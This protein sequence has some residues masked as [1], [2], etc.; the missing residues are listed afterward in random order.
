VLTSIKYIFRYAVPAWEALVRY[1]DKFA[2]DR[3]DFLDPRMHDNLLVDDESFTRLRKYFWALSYLSELNLYIGSAIHQWKGSRDTWEKRFP[4]LDPGS[5]A[6]AQEQMTEIDPL[7]EKL[8]A[9]RIRFQ[10]HHKNITALRDG[11]FSAGKSS[12]HKARRSVRSPPM[13]GSD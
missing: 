10:Q 1:F 2:D 11:L 6:R 9:I 3:K 8:Q 5:W 13:T 7:C 4:E 12:V